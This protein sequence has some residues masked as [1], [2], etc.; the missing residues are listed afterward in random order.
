MAPLL[1][2]EASSRAPYERLPSDTR[3]ISASD[4]DDSVLDID[5]GEENG[6]AKKIKKWW[7]YLPLCCE[8]LS[9]CVNYKSLMGCRIV[10]VILLTAPQYN[11]LVLLVSYYLKIHSAPFLF[12]TH[13][14]II[15]TLTF[16][17]FC[18]LLVLIVRDPGAIRVGEDATSLEQESEDE[19]EETNI[20]DALRMKP[21]PSKPRDDDFN[22]PHKWCRKCWAPKPERTHHC[23]VCDRCVLKMG[24]SVNFKHKK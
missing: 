10:L 1:T 19:N 3:A 18:S 17:S 5:D 16:L 11:I 20:L 13:L 12:V 24:E 15:Y 4:D 6:D 7:N 2:F 23:S 9:I 8:Y 14:S 21:V 22:A